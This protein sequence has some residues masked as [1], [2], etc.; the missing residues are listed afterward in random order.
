M[1]YKVIA[2][3]TLIESNVSALKALNCV[4][5]LMK[6]NTDKMTVEVFYLS[7]SNGEPIWKL[8]NKFTV[9]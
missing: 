5:N 9:N 3:Q 8:E 2:N 4:C 6:T 7:E 1:K